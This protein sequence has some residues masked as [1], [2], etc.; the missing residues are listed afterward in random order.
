MARAG[1]RSV[2]SDPSSPTASTEQNKY[3]SSAAQSVD[4][5]RSSEKI[6]TANTI[7][8]FDRNG[9]ISSKTNR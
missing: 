9:N 6:Y 5:L 3:S 2:G 8:K 4:P 1:R 7:P